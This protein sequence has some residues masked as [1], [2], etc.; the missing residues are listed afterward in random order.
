[1]KYELSHTSVDY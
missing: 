1:M